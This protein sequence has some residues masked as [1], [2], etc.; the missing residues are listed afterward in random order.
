METAILI[1]NWN[2][3]KDTLECLESVFRLRGDSYRIVLCD[4]GS[5]DGSVEKIK[6]WAR[7]EIEAPCA[8]PELARF[9]TPPVPKPI[10]FC[11]LD[12]EQAES[13]R[14]PYDSRFVIIHTGADLGYAGGN[15]VGLRYVLS[16][17]E[18]K[19]YWIINNDITVEPDSLET[20]LRVVKRDSKIGLCGSLNLAYY[21]PQEVQMQGGL[22]YNRWTGRIL[23]Q[24]PRSVAEAHAHPERIDY[25]NGASVLATREFV[26]KVGFMDESY[27]MYFEELDW[28]VRARGEFSIGYAP[29]SVI[30]H[31]E[32]AA[33]GSSRKRKKRGLTS[34]KYVSRNRVVFTKRYFP[35]A[36]PAVLIAVCA[37][38]CER[39]I[40]GDARRAA[41]M[42]H[43]AYKGV[44]GDLSNPL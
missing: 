39:L 17:P 30:Y 8:N 22:R 12:R 4:N 33:L 35:W 7:G 25:V 13:G 11:E 31:K 2:G 28:T 24:P 43:W 9:V 27:F 23:I 1:V 26:E 10:S 20:M 5:T 15:N 32:G 16:D 6:A 14:G 40:R 19:Y 38:A 18:S 44:V 34:E 42:I 41:G 3:W 36:L 37:A 21:S 29:E